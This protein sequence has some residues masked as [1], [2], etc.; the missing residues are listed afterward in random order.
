[1]SSSSKKSVKSISPALCAVISLA[2][3]A[4]FLPL[5]D[6]SACSHKSAK[7]SNSSSS[8]ASCTASS[9]STSSVT[10]SSASATGSSSSTSATSNFSSILPSIADLLPLTETPNSLANAFNSTCVIAF[11]S[12]IEYS[13]STVSSSLT[14]SLGSTFLSFLDALFSATS[15]FASLTTSVKTNSPFDN[16]LTI[17]SK[18]FL[19][20]LF[21]L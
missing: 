9:F 10:G 15:S 18:A 19:K 17:N 16:S 12:S 3:S 2:I 8:N 4:C 14:S 5:V 13:D 1:M 7:S 11:N 6:N 21:I 20:S